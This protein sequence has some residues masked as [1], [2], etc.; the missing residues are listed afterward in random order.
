MPVVKFEW[1][2]SWLRAGKA[3]KWFDLGNPGKYIRLLEHL[4]IAAY[5]RA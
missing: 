1:V 4:A 3:Y 5:W 2:L